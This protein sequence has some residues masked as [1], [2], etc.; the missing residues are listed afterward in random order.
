MSQGG[1]L[2]EPVGPWR[3]WFGMA[4]LFASLPVGLHGQGQRAIPSPEEIIRKAVERAKWAET[5]N[6]AEEFSLTQLV[7]TDKL[8]DGGKVKEH[9]ERLY[10][11]FPI[12][13]T[14]YARLTQKNRK[15][16]SDK[17]VKQEQERERKFRQKLAE[18]K[19]KKDKPKDG[20]DELAFN[21]ELVGK[22]RFEVLGLETINGRAAFLLS[23]EP[24]SRNLP[25]KRRMDRV[26]NK[27]AGKLWLDQDSYEISRVEAHLTE[28][29][30]VGWGILGSVDNVEFLLEQNRV[31]ED[32]WLPSRFD[33]YIKAR[34]LFSLLHQRQKVQWTDFKRVEQPVPEQK[35]AAP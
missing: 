16:L 23:F 10:Q 4:I 9:E 12:D 31:D 17:E 27:L 5:Q 14:L 1:L 25:V 19:R 7:V 29:A 11:G 35:P 13:G 32:I 30:R 34:L 28:K 2:V 6:H 22:Y 33:L 8:D 15:A 26:L 18:S 20:E 24:K 21:E 3:C